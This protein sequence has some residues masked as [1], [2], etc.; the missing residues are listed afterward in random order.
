MGTGRSRGSSLRILAVVRVKAGGVTLIPQVLQKPFGR[1]LLTHPSFKRP[2]VNKRPAG[3]ELQS[4]AFVIIEEGYLP[5]RGTSLCLAKNQL[6]QGRNVLMSHEF[7]FTR[8]LGRGFRLLFC[9][10]GVDLCIQDL[11]PND[12]IDVFEKV[13]IQ[14]IGIDFCRVG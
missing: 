7:S 13:V 8:S 11:M 5:L 6:V 2:L 4:I 10:G 9:S 1:K 3:R 12:D 14:L